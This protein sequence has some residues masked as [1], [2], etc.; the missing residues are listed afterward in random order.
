MIQFNIRVLFT[1][2]YALHVLFR[3]CRFGHGAFL[4]CLE[5]LYK[6]L[7]GNDLIYTA[8]V[9][10]PSEITYYHAETMVQEHARSIG[11]NNSI[12]KLYAI[13]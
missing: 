3:S 7:T 1:N 6:K 2:I 8:L 10:K 11:I 9:G 4:L 13:G 5:A 12:T